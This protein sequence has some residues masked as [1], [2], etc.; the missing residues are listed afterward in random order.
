M[1][2]LVI[3]N[4][5]QN[6]GGEDAVCEEEMALLRR[7]NHQIF[8]YSISNNVIREFGALETLKLPWKSVWAHDSYKGVHRLIKCTSPDVVHLHNTFPLASPSV[9]YA[10]ARERVP[11]VQ[12]LHNFRLLC[13][14]ATFLRDGKVC[15]SCSGRMLAWPAVLHGCYR[16][17]RSATI[18]TAGMLAVHRSLGTWQTKVDVFIAL[19]EFARGKFIAGGLPAD[20]IVVKPN[21]VSHAPEGRSSGG[22]YGLY[23]GRLSEEKG[24]RVLLR[25]AA[26]SSSSILLKVAGDGP[27]LEEARDSM[28]GH[29]DLLGR[30]SPE[31]VVDLMRG[32]RFVIVP[33]IC[34]ENFPLVI[35]ES[36][37]CGVPVI[38]SRLGSL[39]EIVDDGRTG[40]LF[41]PG[42]PQDLA[43]KVDWAWSNPEA[44]SEMGRAARR[45]YECKYTSENNYRMLMEI[46]QRA[47]ASRAPQGRA[48]A[49]ELVEG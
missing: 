44:M 28:A 45:E 9:H 24:I 7:M 3:H 16:G 49:E 4:Y 30:V 33:S 18:A 19:S 17:S 47:I 14:A 1:K 27:L 11:V 46:Y 8:H 25:A 2:I 5:Y 22:E 15:E 43:A 37:A 36:F 35:A 23:A 38:A 32:A 13:P 31:Q 29:V 10:C 34:F 48:V 6:P 39:A 21:F 41:A 12:T 20:R 26:K 42:D 40:L